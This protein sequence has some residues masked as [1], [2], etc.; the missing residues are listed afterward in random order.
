MWYPTTEQVL[1][2]HGKLI[3]HTGGS[4][5]VR[6]VP[7]IESALNRF[8]AS[9]GGEELYPSIEEKAAA[10]ACGLVQ[11]H[12]FIDG[13]KRIGAA[14]LL[15]ILKMNKVALQYTQQELIDIILD[16]ACSKADVAELVSWIHSHRSV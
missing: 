1:I 6:S 12:G 10:T 13:N 5:G 3:A 14:V 4:E 15:L 2:F 9:F 7:L 8:H 11:N 16:I